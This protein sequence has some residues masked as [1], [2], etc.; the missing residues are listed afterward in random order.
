MRVD[1]DATIAKVRMLPGKPAAR[2]GVLLLLALAMSAALAS[3]ALADSATISVTNTAGASDPAAK[4]PRVFTL[5][6]VS[7]AQNE[8]FVKYRA[9]GG[10]PC[11]PSAR[12]DTGQYLENE[13]EFDDNVWDG[14]EVNGDF[15]LSFVDSWPTVGPSMFCIWIGENESAITPPITQVV[16][17]RAPSGTVSAVITPSRPAPNELATITAGGASEAPAEVDATVKTGGGGAPCAPTPTSDSG[18]NV[19]YSNVNGAFSVQSTFKEET[20]GTYELC[21]WLVNSREAS[22]PALAGPVSI[23]F[24]VGYPTPPP[25]VKRPPPPAHCIVPTFS[26]HMTLGSVK[27]R[28]AGSHCRVGLVRYAHSRS[29][30]RGDVI[31]LSPRP[32]SRLAHDA[33]VAVLVSAGR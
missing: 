31:R 32:H 17:F 21:V 6:G 15:N 33:H 28:I 18:E 16:S 12:S 3:A 14:E 10:A 2:F 19:L 5:S 26:T 1:R 7:A 11:A 22:P 29:V 25:P 30:K 20:P 24:V 13:S 4:L 8:I 9:P 27:R 23:P